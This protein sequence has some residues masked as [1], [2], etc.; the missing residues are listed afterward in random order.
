ME[1]S[2]A[3]PAANRTARILLADDSP[4]AQRMGVSILTSLGHEVVAV[5]NGA[6]ALQAL[7]QEHYDILIADVTMPGLSGPELCEMRLRKAEWRAMPAILALAAFEQLEPGASERAFPDAVV[8]KPFEASALEAL[9]QRLLLAHAAAL[10]APAWDQL[11][12]PPK[13]EWKI[14]IRPATDEENQLS[15]AETIAIWREQE[16]QE[17]AARE[18]A[19]AQA[20]PAARKETAAGAEDPVGDAL[21]QVLSRYLAPEMVE[22]AWR[23]YQALRTGKN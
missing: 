4:Q 8:Q 5:S 6:A 16:R 15:I 23:D 21:R 14:Q 12:V 18:A 9:I 10:N 2:V 3:N 22:S 13:R 1:S 11:H 7:E 20:Q 17:R 19:A